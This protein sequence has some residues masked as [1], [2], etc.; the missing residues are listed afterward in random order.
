MDGLLLAVVIAVIFGIILLIVA[1]F[2]FSDKSASEEHSENAAANDPPQ[3]ATP[4]KKGETVTV[5][6]ND[7]KQYCPNCGAERDPSHR[8]C[9]NCGAPQTSADQVVRCPRCGSTNIHF[10]TSQG[11]QRIDKQD[12]CCGYLLCG[13]LGLLCGVKDQDTST[14]RKCMNCNHEF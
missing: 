10:I 3:W 9:S 5:Q 6:H 2:A 4:A 12:A 1:I 7:K 14:V 11:G 13:P 8:F